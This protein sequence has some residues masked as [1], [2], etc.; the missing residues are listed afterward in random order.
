VVGE[1]VRGWWG[2]VGAQVGEVGDGPRVPCMA[3][4]RGWGRGAEVA[5]RAGGGLVGR[6]VV[7][8]S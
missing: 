1:G 5:G 3:R 7:G 2:H 6:N 4:G 8:G